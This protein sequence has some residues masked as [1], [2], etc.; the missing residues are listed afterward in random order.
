MAHPDDDADRRAEENERRM[1]RML[2][3]CPR[4][5]DRRL[6]RNGQWVCLVCESRVAREAVDI[7]KEISIE[8]YIEGKRRAK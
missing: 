6:Q 4:C 7:L 1:E 3:W 8:T 2:E 5:G